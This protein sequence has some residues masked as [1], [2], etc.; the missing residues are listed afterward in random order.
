MEAK[1]CLVRKALALLVFLGLG[2][3]PPEIRADLI[4]LQFSPSNG[5]TESTNRTIGWSFTVSA[6][7]DVTYLAAYNGSGAISPTLGQ[8][9]G[10][11]DSSG[12]QLATATVTTSSSTLPNGSAFL[13]QLLATPVQLNP[14]TTYTVGEYVDN[15]NYVAV[16]STVTLGSGITSFND[17]TGVNYLG[18]EASLS[19]SFTDP[20]IGDP[21]Q[22]D[23][24]FGASFAY[25]TVLNPL[26]T[27]ATPEPA[28]L[29]LVGIALAGFGAR[30][31]WSRRRAK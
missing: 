12:N 16:V 13:Y 18:S 23:G 25:T 19:S 7:I 2:A 27:S 6:A 8:Q 21:P 31:L 9:V 29:A 14:G 1:R 22:N 5:T 30:H 3:C 20:T 10:L 24:R 4:A 17:L 15:M 26:A 28:S 11:W